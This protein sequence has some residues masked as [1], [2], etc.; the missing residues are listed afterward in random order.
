MGHWGTEQ[1]LL[2]LVHPGFGVIEGYGFDLR[3]LGQ[4][5]LKRKKEHIRSMEEWVKYVIHRRN[6]N[7]G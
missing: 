3:P 1:L 6:A 2:D 4:L 7:G 5:S